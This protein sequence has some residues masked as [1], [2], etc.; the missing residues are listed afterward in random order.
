MIEKDIL[1]LIIRDDGFDLSSLQNDIWARESLIRG[2]R[3]ATRRLVSWQAVVMAVAIVG[4][5]TAG[6]SLAISSAKTQSH[7]TLLDAEALAPSSLLF[8]AHL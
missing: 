3:A 6:S 5:A 4:S 2:G 1:L 8:G 7:R